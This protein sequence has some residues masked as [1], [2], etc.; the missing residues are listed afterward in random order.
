MGTLLATVA[1]VAR[2]DLV[3]MAEIAERLGVTHGQVR[4][5]RH[6]K[7]LPEPEWD[8]RNGPLWRWA[9][10]RKWAEETGRLEKE[11]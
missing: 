3:G 11:P 7:Q 2:I 5:W 10:I 1:A 9:T 4:V 8:L 6:R